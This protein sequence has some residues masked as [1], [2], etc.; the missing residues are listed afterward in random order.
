M[1]RLM[2]SE[3]VDL[4]LMPHAYPGPFKAG[5]LV[6]QEDI[7]VAYAKARKIAPLYAHLLGVPAI[8]ANQVGPR[9]REKWAGIIGGLMNPDQIHLLGLSTIADRDGTVK[10]QMDDHI[11]GIIVADVTLDPSHKVCTEPTRYGTYGGGWV[12]ASTSSSA[13]RDIICYVDSFFG[14][15]SYSLSVERRRK[16]RAISPD[17]HTK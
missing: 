6:S 11:E 5:G 1:V 2:Q 3:S 13:A 16:A 8:F 9:G 14:R 4:M 12:D 7:V 10:A 17:G 15:L